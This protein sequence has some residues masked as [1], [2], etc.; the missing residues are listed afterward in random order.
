MARS[1]MY[2]LYMIS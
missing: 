2:I 1:K